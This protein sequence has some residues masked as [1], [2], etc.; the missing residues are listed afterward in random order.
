MIYLKQKNTPSH[1]A[2]GKKQTKISFHSVKVK[3]TEPPM[4]QV[5]DTDI[6]TTAK[7][8]CDVSANFVF[9]C[10]TY[11]VAYLVE[12][13]KS[14]AL[15]MPKFSSS[16]LLSLINN[17]DKPEDSYNFPK[18]LGKRG[19]CWSW[20]KEFPWLCYSKKLDGAFCLPCLLFSCRF[21]T[22]NGN[23]KKLS[24]EPYSHWSNAAYFF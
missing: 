1:G 17:V 13:Y 24:N 5:N 3:S 22:K 21:P 4:L 10:G 11:D 2:V 19:F 8:E 7:R 23:L 6:S 20:L 14:Y 18:I 9:P 12:N 16:L 15:A